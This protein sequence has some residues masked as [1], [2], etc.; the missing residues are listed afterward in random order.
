MGYTLFVIKLFVMPKSKNVL[1]NRPLT[2]L[3]RH[4]QTD[5]DIFRPRPD[6]AKR[7]YCL[8]VSACVCG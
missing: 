5:A 1:I 8:C 7:T 2:S 4:T 6:Q 3:A